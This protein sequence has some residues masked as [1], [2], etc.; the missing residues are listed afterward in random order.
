M[1]F[2][3]VNRLQF[4]KV[5]IEEPL[6]GKGLIYSWKTVDRQACQNGLI[7]I[8]Q[9]WGLL[10][11]HPA[12][13]VC[14]RDFDETIC[15]PLVNVCPQ[16]DLSI[17]LGIVSHAV[18][19]LDASPLWERIS[20]WLVQTSIL[21]MMSQMKLDAEE[22]KYSLHTDKDVFTDMASALNSQLVQEAGTSTKVG[23]STG[24]FFSE[25]TPEMIK[26]LVT[27]DSHRGW[28]WKEGSNWKTWRRRWFC[29][30]RQALYYYDLQIPEGS[31]DIMH[32][33]GIWE[34]DDCV[35]KVS[36]RKEQ[37]KSILELVR[38]NR[39]LLLYAET[40]EDFT[41]WKQILTKA[42]R[43]REDL[44]V[45]LSDAMQETA[46]LKHELQQT[47]AALGDLETKAYVEL[48]SRQDSLDE[49][50]LVPRAQLDHEHQQ[51]AHIR[52]ECDG[53]REQALYM[54]ARMQHLTQE[55][56]E[57]QAKLLSRSQDEELSRARALIQR[58]EEEVEQGR[59][60]WN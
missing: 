49:Q 19:G 41:H 28:L 47:T 37:G 36:D 60:R 20:G 27:F 12:R 45:T 16:A 54:Q 5:R 51:V 53:L 40:E 13:I 25:M 22:L 44:F 39:S 11:K 46:K 29:L 3:A 8:G 6:K 17:A 9:H 35:V 14:V 7:V 34:L 24:H 33:K 58:L 23:T 52:L 57:T 59:M 26:S 2:D 30:S 50:S 4:T 38:H 31:L 1:S 43:N 32:V 10:T 42:C 15:V 56:E 18:N 48:L 21:K 55:L